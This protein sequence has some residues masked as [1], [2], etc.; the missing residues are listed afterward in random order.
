[1]QYPLA[2]QTFLA[3]SLLLSA[4]CAQP[5]VNRTAMEPV[6][7]PSE[8][9]GDR[10]V[11][12]GEWDYEEGA[13]TTLRLDELGNGTYAWKE[14][15]FETVALAGRNWRGMWFQNEND[16]EGGFTVELSPDFMEGVGRWWY[17]RIGEDRAPSQKGGMFHLTKKLSQAKA[18]EVPAP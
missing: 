11:L 12:A 2:R 8:P 3:V 17:T 9:S 5:A 1:M 7:A 15:R 14:G 13:V 10:S 18:G 16:R 6:A 4:A